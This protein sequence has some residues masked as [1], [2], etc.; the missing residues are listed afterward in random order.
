LIVI[1]GTGV[2]PNWDQ[3]VQPIRVEMTTRGWSTL[4]IQMPILANDVAQEGYA[5]LFPKVIPRIESALQYLKSYGSR[6]TEPAG[7]SNGSNMSVYYL[8]SVNDQS[9]K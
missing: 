4:A 8:T 9:I 6:K 3:V 2:Y 7:H 5:K 1:H